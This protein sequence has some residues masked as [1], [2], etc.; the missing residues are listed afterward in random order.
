MGGQLV[1]VEQGA[2]MIEPD[3]IGHLLEQAA[4]SPAEKYISH[5]NSQPPAYDKSVVVQF[6][7]SPRLRYLR[8]IVEFNR[9]LNDFTGFDFEVRAI[10]RS[11]IEVY[12]YAI[13]FSAEK[14]NLVRRQIAR[15]VS[16]YDVCA[17]FHITA[18]NVFGQIVKLGRVDAGV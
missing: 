16:E 14:K 9:V 18:L 15:L 11:C 13:D 3:R 17:Q 2:R 6:K 12:F 8:Y 1:A 4:A 10:K 7:F 5:E